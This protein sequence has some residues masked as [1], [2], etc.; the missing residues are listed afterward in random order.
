MLTTYGL[1]EYTQSGVA[2]YPEQADAGRGEKLLA[3][4]VERMGAQVED[5]LARIES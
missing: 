2:G 1:R 4:L 5:V 3:A